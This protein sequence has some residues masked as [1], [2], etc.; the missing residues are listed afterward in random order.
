VLFQPDSQSSRRSTAQPS[1]VARPCRVRTVSDPVAIGPGPCWQ[2]RD[3]T[4]GRS[5]DTAVI[6]RDAPESAPAPEGS[7]RRRVVVGDRVRFRDSTKVG[8]ITAG[9]G[10]QQDGRIHGNL[11]VVRYDDHSPVIADI[12]DL[13][14]SDCRRFGASEPRPRANG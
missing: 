3:E 1:P 7:A 8:V 13:M 12:E 9:T 11:V 6:D 5:D 2:P 4:S 10:Q 14:C